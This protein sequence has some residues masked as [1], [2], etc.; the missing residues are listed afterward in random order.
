MEPTRV[1]DLLFGR[2]CR[3]PICAWV[4]D[5]DKRFH[6]SRVPTFGTTSRSNIRTELDRLV[7]AGMLHEDRPGDGRVHYEMTDSPLWQ[8]V[9]VAV[10]ATGLQWH[11]DRLV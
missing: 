7:S 8:I 6:Q 1:S 3:L 5:H 11:D 4:R 10:T 2:A 9:D